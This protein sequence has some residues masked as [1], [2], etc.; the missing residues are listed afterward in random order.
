MLLDMERYRQQVE[1]D[2]AHVVY[3]MNGGLNFTDA[4]HL[5]SEQ[6]NR[7]NNTIKTHFEKQEEAI[8]QSSSKRR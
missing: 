5:T 1:D 7:L 6:I 8:K 3:Y 4:Y 2:I